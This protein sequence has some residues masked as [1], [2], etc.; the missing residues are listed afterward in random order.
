MLQ[1]RTRI[2]ARDVLA[3]I[4]WLWGKPG[5]LRRMLPDYVRYYLP[6]FHPWQQDNSAL[7][8]QWKA[9]HAAATR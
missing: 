5:P 2:S 8:H 1:D 7:V 9:E 3:G 4:Y 6:R